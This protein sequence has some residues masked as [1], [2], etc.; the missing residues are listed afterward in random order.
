MSRNYAMFDAFAK[1][2]K[3]ADAKV[4]ASFENLDMESVKTRS[5]FLQ[6]NAGGGKT[7]SVIEF[8]KNHSDLNILA[9]S[10]TKAATNEIEKR[11]KDGLRVMPSNIEVRT[12]DAFAWRNARAVL[13]PQGNSW[14]IPGARYTNVVLGKARDQNITVTEYLY[15]QG[16]ILSTHTLNRHIL[17]ENYVQTSY[18]VVIVDEAQDLCPVALKFLENCTGLSRFLIYVGDEKQTIYQSGCIFTK[19][20]TD[21]TKFQFTHTFRY[22]GEEILDLINHSIKPEARHTAFMT[23]RTSVTYSNYET[24]RRHG[25]TTVLVTTWNNLL[26]YDCANMYIDPVRKKSIRKQ[27]Q[28]HEKC[29]YQRQIYDALPRLTQSFQDWMIANNMAE[30]LDYEA[31]KWENIS[32]M[33]D[34]NDTNK[35]NRRTADHIKTVHQMK[36]AETENVYMD[37]SCLPMRNSTPATPTIKENLYYVALTRASKNVGCMQKYHPYANWKTL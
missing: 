17:L 33:L 28:Q 4:R 12:F 11:I 16:K 18:D 25:Q 9:V 13:K 22:D 19:K 37:I 10:H 32:R 20:V 14:C 29:M 36:G 23:K 27:C 30:L 21:V 8:I 1:S 15:N 24:F 3:P 34:L 26:Y 5:I 6:A 7:H 31:P 2:L 35:P